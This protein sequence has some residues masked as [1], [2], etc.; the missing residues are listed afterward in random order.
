MALTKAHNRMIEGAAA[1][2]KDFGAVGDGV[3]DDTAAIQAA[4]DYATG[5]GATILCPQGTYLISSTLS[6]PVD[7]PVI[8]KG[9][10]VETTHINYTGSSDLFDMYDAGSSTKY[11][12]SS[13]EDM[14]ISGN[15][16]TSVNGLN[17]RNGYAIALRN[18][19]IY[20]F[21]VGVR[22]E[23]T[24]SVILD[25]VRIDSCSQVGLELHSEAN[26]IVCTCCEFLDNAKGIYTAGARAILFSGCTIEANTS[27]GAHVTATTADSQS[28]NIVFEGCYIEGN[29]TAEIFVSTES[30]SVHPDNTV[31]RDCY[32]VCLTGRADKGVR[33]NQ[34]DGLVIDSCY[35]STGTA[36][37]AYSLYISDS[38]TVSDIRFGTNKDSSTNGVYRGTGTTYKS[39]A[40]L[41]AKCWGRFTVSGAA[42]ATTRSFGITSITYVSTGLYEV[43]MD[44][45]ASGTDYSV[46]AT[47]ENGSTYNA[48]LC[49]AQP[50]VSSTVFRIST[51]SDAS[52]TAEAR[53]VSF[54]VY[55]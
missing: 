44:T 1:N 46:V 19:R 53:T 3:T 15:G 50:P 18:V 35:F 6:W 55:D 52:T 22:I 34:A 10:G 42:I 9:E 11:V 32:F 17:I 54:V 23:R 49:S 36:T 21:E 51:A 27:Y 30:G 7:W 43:T 39:E 5:R 33:A 29:T 20:N 48:M 37:Y 4:I 26:N 47:A 2:V 24:W 12:K 8:L 41:E 40:K 14:R 25:F 45:A 28:E 16:S 31:I 13:I 38:G